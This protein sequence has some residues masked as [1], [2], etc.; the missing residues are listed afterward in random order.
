MSDFK[1]NGF[2]IKVAPSESNICVPYRVVMKVV[3][4]RGKIETLS[5]TDSSTSPLYSFLVKVDFKGWIEGE[6]RP[7]FPLKCINQ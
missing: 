3:F 2:S 6:K 4:P 5:N 7:W 1:H